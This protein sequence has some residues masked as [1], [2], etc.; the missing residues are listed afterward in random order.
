MPATLTLPSAFIR[1]DNHTPTG[2]FVVRTLPSPTNFML[3][4]NV[5]TTNAAQISFDGTNGFTINPGELL[6]FELVRQRTY[7][8]KASAGSPALQVLLGSDQ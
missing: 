1:H 6:C 4:R 5:D 7:W 3:I 8:T 2:S